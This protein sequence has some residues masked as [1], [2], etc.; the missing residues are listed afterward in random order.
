MSSTEL[1]DRHSIDNRDLKADN[2]FLDK[3]GKVKIMDFFP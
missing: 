2:I 1:P 3:N